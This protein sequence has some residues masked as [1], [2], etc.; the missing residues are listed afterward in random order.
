[1]L[2]RLELRTFR[3]F[4]SLTWEPH[5]GLNFITGPNAQ[6]KTSLLEAACILLRLKSP[7]TNSLGDVAQFG[8][9]AF[10]LEGNYAERHLALRATP[11]DIPRRRL[12]IDGVEQKETSDYLSTGRIVWFG[13]NDLE[14]IRG[15]AERRRR[16]LDSAGLQ[17]GSDYGRALRFYERALRA[18]NVLLREGRSRREIEA[19]NQPLV[20]SGDKLI[21]ARS[22][23]CKDLAPRA[24]AACKSISGEIMILSYQPGATLPMAEALAASRQEESRLRMTQ[25]GPQRDDLLIMLNEISASAF[26]SEGQCRTMALALKLAL[27]SL[28]DAAGPRP[29]LLL[30]DDVFGELDHQRRQA[31]LAGLPANAQALL[32]TTEL[33]N[34]RLPEQSTVFKLAEGRFL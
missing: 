1:M 15:A 21:A 2:T 20:E 27:A 8:K 19:Y 6:G 32:T 9:N 3:C 33:E 30:L 28:L 29:P 22:Q 25:V 24:E 4:S 10:A 18:R 34:I 16:F 17:L 12:I 13:S 5:E 31:L 7:R 11:H 14:M 26:A 23:L